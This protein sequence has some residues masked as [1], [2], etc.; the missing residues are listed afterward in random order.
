MQSIVTNPHAI[1]EESMKIIEQNLP[2]L[3]QLSHEHREIVKRVIHTTGDLTISEL[4]HI[5]PRAVIE[6][7][8]AVRAG[9][10]IVTDVNMLKAGINKN[11]LKDLG[12]N[13]HCYISDP[14]IAEESKQTG[15]TRAMI[16]M[17]RAAAMASGGIIAIGNAPTALF[18]LC[19]LIKEGKADPALIV[20]TPVG[21]VGAR[22]SKEQLMQEENIPYITLPGTRGGSNIAAS[23]VNALLYL[24]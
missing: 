10:P 24:A 15:I 12:I 21:F 11:R 6:G 22:E 4:V 5:H 7:L 14:D 9:R 17:R 19:E 8:K 13:V 23:I 1:E 18:A 16:S 2:Q 3:Q 20:G